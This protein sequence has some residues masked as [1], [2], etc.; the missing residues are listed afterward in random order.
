[1]TR[2]A[3]HAAVV[4]LAS[5]GSPTLGQA[6]F[7]GLETSDSPYVSRALA[8]SADGRVVV[9]HAYDGKFQAMR[10]T[11]LGGMRLLGALPG[12][13]ASGAEGISANGT[14]IVGNSESAASQG[15]F[16][17]FRWSE[18]TGWIGLGDLG[19]GPYQSG[20]AGVSNDGKVVGVYAK[21]YTPAV[22]IEGQG[23]SR[24]GHQVIGY[25]SAVTRDSAWLVGSEMPNDIHCDQFATLWKLDGTATHLGYLGQGCLDDD[26][27]SCYYPASAWASAYAISADQTTLVGTSTGPDS[28]AW[29]AARWTPEVEALGLLPGSVTSVARAVSADGSV[30]AGYSA[31][32]STAFLWKPATGMRPLSEVLLES[33]ALAAAGW[34]LRDATGISDDGRVVVGWGIDAGGSQA[35]WIAYLSLPCYP[36]IDESASLDL[37]DFLAFV[38]LFNAGSGYA[39]CDQS[40]A[41][42]L[43][44]FLCFTNAF[45]AGC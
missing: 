44:D 33:G 21:N 1:M 27:Q 10:W 30:V 34:T 43:F 4:L 39:D 15:G 6:F 25:V 8:V 7:Q 38:N 19:G 9:G 31:F 23:L 12:G 29:L 5:F 16:E 28:C 26:P 45:N 42:D 17:A 13:D 36:D 2:C 14:F 37:F 35:A 32:P 41:L 40:G 11:R 3:S 22:W 24:L 18:E 20:A